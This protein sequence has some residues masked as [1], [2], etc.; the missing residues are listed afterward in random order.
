MN[1]IQWN[2]PTFASPQAV[3]LYLFFYH[4]F[5]ACYH[6]GIHVAALF[7]PKAKKWVQGRKDIFKKLSSAIAPTDQ[8]V[9][10]HCASLGEFEQGRPLLEAIR[11]QYPHYKLLLTFFSPSGY[12]V[13]K[14]YTGANWVFYMPLDGRK[15]S[16]K[17]LNIV[18]PSLAIF[19][20]YEFWYFYLK[21]L[22]YR[23][24][25]LLLVAALFRKEMSFFSWHGSIHRKMA[26]R[27]D[28]IFVQN[29]SS[30][31]LLAKI[32]LGSIA[33]IAGDTRF[34]RVVAI[35]KEAKPLDTIN[36][37]GQGQPLFIAGST[38]PN[39]E[40]LLAGLA[41]VLEHEKVKLIIAPHQIS[42]SHLLSIE[43]NFPHSIRLSRWQAGQEIDKNVL[44]VDNYGLLSS[45]YQYATLAYIGGGLQSSGIHNV[46]EAAVYGIPVLFGPYYK[47]YAEA[48]A[49]VQTGGGLPLNS[50]EN[51]LQ[52]LTR[53]TLD[54]L[55]EE[56]KRKATGAAAGQFV[57][58]HTGAT[59][60]VLHYIQENRLLIN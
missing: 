51:Y 7:N 49:L 52:Q 5:L 47:K 31:D 29:S 43:N 50:G 28:Q 44:I 25:P 10:M 16:K 3:N 60:K 33:T 39:D 9:W 32:G 24:T 27:F 1:R 23:K 40:K 19:V 11:V 13:Q 8:V 46:L 34:D 45:L 15:R 20:K 18:H 35:A 41:P 6:A 58:T 48:I 59:L 37:F 30:R 21:K 56:T 4:I 12:E 22:S 54:L 14:N 53:I 55:H 38:W 57:Q 42:E 17:F 26:S 36:S 2:D